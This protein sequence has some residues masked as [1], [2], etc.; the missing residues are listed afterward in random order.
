M[1]VYR[2][3][4]VNLERVI[5][6]VQECLIKIPDSVEIVL[7]GDFNVDLLDKIKTA[8]RKLLRV[9]NLNYSKQVISQLMRITAKSK[10][11][12]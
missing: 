10:R 5:E 11:F 7:L 4:N 1:T 9:M 2:A 8:A 6:E 3:P 12:D